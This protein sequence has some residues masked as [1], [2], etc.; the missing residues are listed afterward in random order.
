M[1]DRYRGWKDEEWKESTREG[2]VVLNGVYKSS[3]LHLHTAAAAY[4]AA[5]THHYTP[6]YSTPQHTYNTLHDSTPR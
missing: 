4:P 5:R 6:Y 2:F 1:E 3:D